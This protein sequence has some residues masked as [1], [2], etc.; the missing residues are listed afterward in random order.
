MEEI[1]NQYTEK[2]K[3]I[4]NELISFCETTNRNYI[5]ICGIDDFIWNKLVTNEYPN[6][7]NLIKESKDKNEIIVNY[8]GNHILLKKRLKLAIPYYEKRDIFEKPNLN[9][10]DIHELDDDSISN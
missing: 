6:F 4:I 10:I 5:A 1:K 7:G 9:I 2:L 8:N 3:N